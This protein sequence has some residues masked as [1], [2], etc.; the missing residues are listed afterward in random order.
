MFYRIYCILGKIINIKITPYFRRW[1]FFKAMFKCILFKYK[2]TLKGIKHKTISSILIVD[3][4]L[5]FRKLL[6]K[7]CF[8]TFPIIFI[9]PVQNE[10]D[11]IR[12][13]NINKNHV[14]RCF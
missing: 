1:S 8:H 6:L 4:K 10:V 9:F 11:Q 2:H 3:E 13:N 7:I 5:V 12:Y 14:A